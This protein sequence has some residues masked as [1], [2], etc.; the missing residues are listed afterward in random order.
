[1]CVSPDGMKPPGM[2]CIVLLGNYESLGS[3][4]P[5]GL[6]KPLSIS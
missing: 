6:L 5:S 3:V 4:L 2:N 1:M